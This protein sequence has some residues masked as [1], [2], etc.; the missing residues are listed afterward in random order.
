MRPLRV[1]NSLLLF[2]FM[3]TSCSQLI[4]KYATSFPG[5]FHQEWKNLGK[6][7][8]MIAKL[9]KTKQ[10]KTKQKQ[11]RLNSKQK[12]ILS[13]VTITKCPSTRVILCLFQ[14]SILVVSMACCLYCHQG[15]GVLCFIICCLVLQTKAVRGTRSLLKSSPNVTRH[16]PRPLP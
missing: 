4:Y 16:V 6:D 12:R 11:K 15:Y 8:G 13:V 9:F 5:L 2:Y 3:R 14:I 1:K 10:N 7:I